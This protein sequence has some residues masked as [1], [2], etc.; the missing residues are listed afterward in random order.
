M[1]VADQYE[2]K[3]K[4]EAALKERQDKI[5]EKAENE[6]KKIEQRKKVRSIFLE[7]FFFY[8]PTRDF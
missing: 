6:K 1:A 2:I 7:S 3:R 8:V 5:A 4:K